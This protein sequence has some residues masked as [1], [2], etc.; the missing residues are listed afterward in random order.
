[1]CGRVHPRDSQSQ[2]MSFLALLKYTYKFDLEKLSEAIEK[3]WS[4]YIQIIENENCTEDDI[5]GARA[6]LYFIGYLYVEN[7]ALGAIKNRLYD[8]SLEDFLVKADKGEID[9]DLVKFYKIIKDL[10]NR[11]YKGSY[12]GEDLFNEVY[13]K[14]TGNKSRHRLD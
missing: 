5:Y 8:M 14:V 7:I 6:I 12:L 13:E 10:K 2:Q 11:E 3:L 1:M 9:N 4:R